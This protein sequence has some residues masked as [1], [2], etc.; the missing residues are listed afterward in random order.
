M[1]RNSLILSSL[2]LLL[3][4]PAFSQ[5]GPVDPM[6]AETWHLNA[7]FGAGTPFF[8]NGSG[9]GPAAK[10][11]FEKGMWEVGPGTITLG[12]ELTFSYFWNSYGNG[13]HENW[14]NMIAGARSAY[15]Y[16]WKVKGLDTYAGIPLGFGVCMNSHDADEG[17]HN[18]TPFYP[19]FGVFFG[20][21]YFF[22]KEFGVYGEFGYN[23]TYANLGLVFRL[24]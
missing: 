1:I 12:A 23:S 19:Y 11:S 13:W 7:A 10:F 22:T 14:F 3:S 6:L 5:K 9:F 17:Y 8:G 2:I 18:P 20:A 21:S 15:H 16:G 24:D 4:F